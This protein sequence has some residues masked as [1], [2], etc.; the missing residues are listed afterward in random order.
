M[1][2]KFLSMGV[3]WQTRKYIRGSTMTKSLKK[4]AAPSINLLAGLDAPDVSARSQETPSPHNS[5]KWDT[6]LG[7]ASPLGSSTRSCP[8]CGR[9]DH[10]RETVYLFLSGQ[11]TSWRLHAPKIRKVFGSGFYLPGVYT[12]RRVGSQILLLQF[13]HFLLVP[14]Q[15]SKDMEKS[16]NSCDPNAWKTIRGPKELSPHISSLCSLQDPRETYLR[17]C[18][19]NRRPFAPEGA[20]GFS[21]REVNRPSGSLGD[22]GHRG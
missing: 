6:R 4:T 17:S 21:T 9:S 7:A 14:T 5:W 19:T 22:L 18:R 1:F 15:N 11:G 12:P 16:T 2:F 20:G 13:P 8:T 3:P 10:L